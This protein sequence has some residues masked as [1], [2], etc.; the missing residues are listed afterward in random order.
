MRRVPRPWPLLAL[1]AVAAACARM[2]PP[3]GGPPDFAPPRLVGTFPESVAVLPDFDGWVEFT[4]D[5]VVSEGSQPN[6]G[7][8]SGDLEQLVMISPDSG[9]P[10]VRWRRE[11]I[12]VQPREGWRPGIVYRVELASGVRDL[13]SPPN[14]RDTAAVVTFTT[15][16]PLPTRTLF[17]RAV[18]WLQR[19][20]APR[21]LVEVVL[22]P[23]SLV[24]RTVADSSGRFRIGPLPD[25]EYLVR[26]VLDNNGNRRRE[27]R[28]GWDTVRLAAGR[29]S[30][31]EVWAFLRDTLPP[32]V[33]QSGVSQ[34]DSFAIA[35]NLSQPVDPSLRLG[36]DAV[37]VWLA[38]DSVALPA[39]SAMPAAA[40]D[41]I[42]APID[43]ARRA[44]A[45]ARADTAVADTAVAVADTAAVVQPPQVR[46]RPGRADA[47]TVKRE[48]PL[49]PRPPLGTR[50]VI[51]LGAI[52]QPGSRYLIELRGVRAMSGAVAD[53]IRTQLEI[54][55]PRRPAADSVAAPADS[56][57]PP[58]DT[59]AAVPAD[60]LPSRR[61]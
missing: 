13:A 48:E 28:E 20:F 37:S 11:R 15:G 53:T 42:Y 22:L 27:P 9:V 17:G 23:D 3:P 39:M 44:Q 59:T 25:G 30:V 4:F 26:V 54:Q 41:S 10:R 50:L 36:S 43:S 21:A 60:T 56:T 38:P 14:S 52:L 7:F 2:A 45:R 29:D 35:I 12:A 19:R 58:A 46:A 40:H 24:Y 5:E 6:F 55:A 8:G 49:E 31:G 32:R 1:A 61:Q 18:D 47:D 57:P 33:E 16:A 51:R 34:L